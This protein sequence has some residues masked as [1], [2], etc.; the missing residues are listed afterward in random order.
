[1]TPRPFSIIGVR[2]KLPG[3]LERHLN[4]T[5]AGLPD[6]RIK[7]VSAG[8]GGIVRPRKTLDGG[9]EVIYC[10][11]CGKQAGVVTIELPPGVIYVCD[12]C[13]ERMGPLPLEAVSFPV[14]VE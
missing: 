8:A 4:A 14:P 5:R 7:G 3:A 10:L 2:I 9:L 1:M 12:E 13:N 11:N 6:S